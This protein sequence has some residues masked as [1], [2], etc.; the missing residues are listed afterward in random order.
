[1]DGGLGRWEG[2]WLIVFGGIVV[3]VDGPLK[4]E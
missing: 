1:M 2:V 4:V 3:V